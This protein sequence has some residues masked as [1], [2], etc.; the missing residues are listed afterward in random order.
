[1]IIEKLKLKAYIN[2]FPIFINFSNNFKSPTKKITIYT[3]D[4]LKKYDGYNKRNRRSVKLLLEK[5]I[6]I[7]EINEIN[8]NINVYKMLFKIEKLLVKF[9]K[10]KLL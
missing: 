5:F 3:K 4:N 7:N 2:Q 8:E 1:M 6:K 10:N 9:N